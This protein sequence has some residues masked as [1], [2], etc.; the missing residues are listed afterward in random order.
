[1]CSLMYPGAF[2]RHA[3]CLDGKTDAEIRQIIG[4]HS[5]EK[6]QEFNSNFGLSDPRWQNLA[7]HLIIPNTR[8]EDWGTERD[9]C[10]PQ[11]GNLITY[12]FLS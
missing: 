12:F 4:P 9:Q 10:D 1:M 8:E 3:S 11:P 5:K 2:L 6:H 7:R